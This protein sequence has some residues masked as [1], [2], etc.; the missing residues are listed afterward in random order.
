LSR[1]RTRAAFTLL[2]LI[3]V[4][5]IIGLVAG[6]A[7]PNL[8][9]LGERRLLDEARR[10]KGELELARQRSIVTGVRH[11]LVLDLDQARYWTECETPEEEPEPA[12]ARSTSDRPPSLSP[13]ERERIVFA[14][15]LDASGRGWPLD[16]DVGFGGV[17]T[18]SRIE[19]RGQFFVV[20]ESD[21][22][23]DGAS[24]VLERPD[25]SARILEVRAL[26]EAV[27]VRDETG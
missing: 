8:G 6:L 18:E 19:K 14:P 21:G 9:F 15:C 20:F 22:S 2:E 1:S 23:T 7:L 17:E 12:P 3:A 26:A 4:V 13:P 24:I 11:R 27:L 16:V 5:L 25:G 10:L